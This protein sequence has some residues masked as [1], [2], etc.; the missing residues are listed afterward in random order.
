MIFVVYLSKT[1]LP[2]LIIKRKLYYIVCT[3]NIIL[4]FVL[5]YFSHYNSGIVATVKSTLS[6]LIIYSFAYLD[7]EVAI[8]FYS[9]L[10]MTESL[11]RWIN[12]CFVDSIIHAKCTTYHYKKLNKKCNRSYFNQILIII[13]Y[14][15]HCID[16]THCWIAR[17]SS[18]NIVHLQ[19]NGW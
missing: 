17:N 1:K 4:S 2:Q 13:K 6:L 11:F 3:L 8:G 10:L 16:G 14:I 19:C 7:F 9:Y 5:P 15:L 18:K 12:H